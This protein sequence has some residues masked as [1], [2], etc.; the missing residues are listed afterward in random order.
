MEQV[1][2]CALHIYI[3]LKVLLILYLIE[4]LNTHSFSTDRDVSMYFKNE[5]L[6]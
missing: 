2:F 3:G 5:E 4:A 6:Y 1:L